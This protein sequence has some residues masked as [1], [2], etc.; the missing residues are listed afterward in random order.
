MAWENSGEWNQKI[1]DLSRRLESL[2]LY[3]TGQQVT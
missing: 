2:P 3:A 1:E